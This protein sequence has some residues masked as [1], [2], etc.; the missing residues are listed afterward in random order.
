MNFSPKDAAEKIGNLAKT[1]ITEDDSPVTFLIDESLYGAVPEPYP[2][3]SDFPNWYKNISMFD[4]DQDGKEYKNNYTIRGCRPFMQS[5]SLGWMI[6]LT[7]D[8]HIVHDEDGIRMH[9]S[10]VGDISVIETQP[11]SSFGG[12]ENMPIKGSIAVK[13]QSP[14]YISV[15]EGYSVFNLPILN[16]PGNKIDKYFYPFSG[17]WDA[18]KFVTTVD[19]VSLMDVPKETNDVIKAGTPVCQIAVVNKNAFL[20]N[21]KTDV[22][23]E[24]QNRLIKKQLTLQDVSAHLYSDHLWEPMKSSRMIQ[25]DNKKTKGC[26]FIDDEQINE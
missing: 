2:A 8:L 9:F 13:F 20:Y 21:G 19:Q 23:T 5:L 14:W 1:N 6:P 3:S 17:I 16:R 11:K 24:K 26:P 12:S 7:S 15:P 4:K 10:D 18:D 22:L 25:N